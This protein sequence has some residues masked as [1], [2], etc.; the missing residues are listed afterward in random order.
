MRA[1]GWSLS[2][3][4][5]AAPALLAQQPQ[6]T[7]PVQAP[8]LNV[9]ANDSLMNLLQQWEQQM[10]NIK[11]I[12]ATVSRTTI[13]KVDDTRVVYEGT[14]KL[15]RPDRAELYLRKK[16]NPQIYER[17]VLTG[18]FLYQFVP[19]E[20]KLRATQLAR[21]ERAKWRSMTTSWACCS[22]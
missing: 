19:Q 12:D 15:L 21:A 2:I 18:N 20:K 7:R 4:F 9:P 3:T 17:I 14:A 8:P 6:Y 22:A 16:T 1:F 11:A 5:L 13:D 10:K